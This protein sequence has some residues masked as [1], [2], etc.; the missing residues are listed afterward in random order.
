LDDEFNVKICDFGASRYFN[1]EYD[2]M[3]IFGTYEYMPPE[4]VYM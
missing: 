1:D 4:V 2:L 3:D